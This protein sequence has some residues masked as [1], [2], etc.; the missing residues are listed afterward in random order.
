MKNRMRKQYQRQLNKKIKML[1]K[2]IENDPLWLGRFYAYQVDCRWCRFQDNS[3]GILIA[4]IRMVDKKTG[5][6]KDYRLEY[7]P[8]YIT[9][10]WHIT[11]DIAN[12]FVVEYLQESAKKEEIDWNKVSRLD[13]SKYDYAFYGGSINV[14]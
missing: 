8:Y 13:L 11:M 2:S 3:G 14:K 6:Y 7:A 9:I 5:K 12:D 4:F 10:N 1:N